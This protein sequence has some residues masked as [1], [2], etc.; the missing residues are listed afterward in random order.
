MQEQ[1]DIL[2]SKRE[3]KVLNRGGDMNDVLPELRRHGFDS[4]GTREAVTTGF[5]RMA[6]A[7]EAYAE[8]LDTTSLGCRRSDLT[9][10]KSM[11]L[12]CSFFEESMPV[13][14]LDTTYIL[15]EEK[16]DESSI[17]KKRASRSMRRQ[18]DGSRKTEELS[19]FAAKA[20]ELGISISS[21]TSVLKQPSKE[22]PSKEQP[23]LFSLDVQSVPPAGFEQINEDMFARKDN[24]FMVFNESGVHTWIE[25]QN[26]SPAQQQP[27]TKLQGID[28]DFVLE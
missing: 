26:G 11:K 9:S 6:K 22:Q 4:S 25:H 21:R 20:A 19:S 13:S 14:R 23:S 27:I 10:E 2:E 12:Y 15:G 28:Q 18:Q 1:F 24:K 3:R 8:I 7:E 16:S 17:T 5:N